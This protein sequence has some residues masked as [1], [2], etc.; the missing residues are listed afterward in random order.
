MAATQAAYDIIVVGSGVA[1]LWTAVELLRARPRLRIAVYE[2]AP[3]PGGRAHTF[4]ATV[5]GTD[6]QWE[7]GAGRISERHT[8]LLSLL[9]RYKLKFSPIG[10]GLQYKERP[11]TPLEPNLFE[12]AI[13]VLIDTLAAIPKEELQRQTVRQL[14][15]KIHGPAMTDAYLIRFPYRAEVDIMRAD[16]ALEL[17]RGEMRQHAGY[18][19]CPQGLSSVVDG[20]VAELKRRRGQLFLEHELVTIEQTGSSC[21]VE[22]VFKSGPAADGPARR[23]V[24]VRGRRA[25]LAMPV[26]ALR[27]LRIFQEWE[28]MR[29]LTMTPLLRFYGVFP[30][31]EDGRMWTDKVGA[32]GRIVTA[33]PVRYVIP[34]NPAIGSVQISY[35]DSQDAEHW[36]RKLDAEG[37]TKVGTEIVAQLRELLLPSI[38]PPTFLKA[39]PWRHGVSYWLPG[40]YEPADVSQQAYQPFPASRPRIHVCGESFSLRQGWIEGALEHADGLVRRLLRKKDLTR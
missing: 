35:T 7:A 4:K 25:V 3:G 31:D 5:D 8:H 13:P 27:K 23:E 28:P 24:V 12:P 34:G 33:Q 38:P 16:R 17:F 2:R 1:G 19:I 22:A 37:E 6:L 18:G 36:I 29:H 10:G 32:G 26:E 15:T 40:A 20:L 39:H 21:L 11:S 14:L 9:R 30:K